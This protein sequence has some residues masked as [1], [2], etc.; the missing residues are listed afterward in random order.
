MHVHNPP[1]ESDHA[2]A[3]LIITRRL[4]EDG[5]NI[6]TSNTDE[7]ADPQIF[8]QN[9]EMEFSFYFIR[10]NPKTAPD[11]ETLQRWR[12]LTE[13]HQVCSFYIPVTLSTGNFDI[14]PIEKLTP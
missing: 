1:A 8:A 10:A 9:Q 2:L 13:H 7:T 5:C 4:T 14:I 3:V 6:I 12:K 11:V